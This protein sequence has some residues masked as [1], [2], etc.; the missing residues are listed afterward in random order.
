MIED[1]VGEQVRRSQERHQKFLLD[2]K[3]RLAKKRHE[4]AR[5]SEEEAIEMAARDVGH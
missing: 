4:N 2:Y 1:V 5:F 3:F